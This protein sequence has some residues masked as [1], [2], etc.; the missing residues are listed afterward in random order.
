[1]TYNSRPWKDWTGDL[2]ASPPCSASCKV[3]VKTADGV[4]H[5][6]F[7]DHFDWRADNGQ[8]WNVKK[9]RHSPNGEIERGSK[10]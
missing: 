4:T 7:A 5:R 2:S 9:W 1:M 8:P 3:E 6:D 10:E